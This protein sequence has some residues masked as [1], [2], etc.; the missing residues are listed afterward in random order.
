[1]PP[2]RPGLHQR[3][4]TAD[5]ARELMALDAARVRTERLD[6]GDAH[7]TLA[8]HLH[9]IARAALRASGGTD[10]AAVARQVALANR[11]AAAIVEET[12][13]DGWVHGDPRELIEVLPA[14]PGDGPAGALPEP[15]P[16]PSVPLAQ[17]ALLMNARG[18]PNIGGEVER[19]LASADRVDLLCAFVKWH[20]VR[21]I[22]DAVRTLLARTGTRMRLITST[23]MGATEVRAIE[24]LARLGV[25]VHLSFE[26]Q[27]TKLHAK[28]WLFH[29]DTGFSTA[30]VGSSNLSKTAL[31][32]GLEWNVRL[33]ATEQPH[34]LD[35]FAGAFDEYWAD[36]RFERYDPDDPEQEER[37]RRAV[38]D[39]RSV[40]RAPAQALPLAQIDV[41]PYPFQREILELLDTER[42]V[43]G[44]PH[45]LVVMATGTGKTIVSGL[46]YRRLR[47]AGTVGRLLF[48]AHREEILRQSLST[49][50]Q[51]VGDPGF[52]ELMVGGE[53]PARGEHVFASI[54]SLARLDL[55]RA[56]APDH[57]DMVIV[58]EFHHAG[59]ETRTYAR[60]LEHLRPR[61][62]L[63][64]TATPERMDGGDVTRWFGGRIAVEMRLWEALEQGLVCPFHYFGVDDGTDLR[65]LRFRRGTGYDVDQLTNVFTGDDLRVRRILDEVRERVADVAAMR[66]VGFCV[67]IDHAEFMARRFIDGGIAAAAITSRTGPEERARL[68][69]ALRA[70]TVNILFTVDLLNEGLDIPDIDTVLFLRPTESATIFLQQLGRGLRRTPDK[71]CLTV[72]DFIGHQSADFRLD[73]RFRALTGAS[74]SGLAREVQGR[75]PHLP[76]GCHIRLDRQTQE[77]VLEGV[78]RALRVNT[79]ELTAELRRLG[80]VDLGTFLAETGLEPEDLY[81]GSGRTWTELRRAAGHE[82]RAPADPKRDGALGKAIGRL[83]HIDDPERLEFLAGLLASPT[84][85]VVPADPRGRRLLA[86]FHHALWGTSLSPVD[87]LEQGLRLLWSEPA[88]RDELAALLPLLAARRHRVTEPLRALRPVPL[89][90]HARYTRNEALAAFGMRQPASVR[91]GVKWLPDEDADILF[92]TLDK[93]ADH[94][95]PTTMYEDRALTPDLFQWESQSTTSA[96]S[97]TGRRYRDHVAGGSGVHLFVRRVKKEADGTTPP[98]LY[99]GPAT[100]REHTGSRPMRILWELRHPLPAD[101]FQQ[102]RVATG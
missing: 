38:G 36:P 66:A 22:E 53:R 30:Y 52:G 48:V 19:E 41:Q 79:K 58:D 59:P 92:V 25:D 91:E 95:S 90:V 7:E 14:P 12:D 42:R 46:D 88:R 65:G 61:I 16:R 1:M 24:R 94:Y 37:L 63:G 56:L 21:L 99:A 34:L 35:T 47:D 29:R 5:L 74:R 85:P 89:Q 4:V 57:F 20:G 69:Q 31:V 11:I 77:R 50:R 8:R 2:P 82:R 84:V 78:K 15:L 18:Q 96:D 71:P 81:R 87:D 51:I 17:S 33:S 27:A 44:R 32:D 80:D 54:Q 49:F 23:Y 102:A 75:F 73:L 101:V 100:Y 98:Y 67:S 83:L 13:C 68:L 39:Q 76:A 28:A 93:T 70:R 43:H 55:E 64:L 10:T 62:L 86:M 9:A 97:P 3:L 60:L 72:L 45:S 40:E 26:D 6:P